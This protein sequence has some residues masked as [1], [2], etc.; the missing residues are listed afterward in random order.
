MSV[1]PMG[2]VDSRV[3]EKSQSRESRPLA[4]VQEIR[5]FQLFNEQ[6]IVGQP[7]TGQQFQGEDPLVTI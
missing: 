1:F 4:P 3:G 2:S 5:G 7:Q 6:P